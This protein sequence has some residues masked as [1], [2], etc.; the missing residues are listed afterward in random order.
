MSVLDGNLVINKE[1]KEYYVIII[2][3]DKLITVLAK[4]PDKNVNFFILVFL[5]LFVIS[6]V[7]F[8]FHK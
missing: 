2:K 7:H 3:D 4:V 5:Y 6:F 1:K 8:L